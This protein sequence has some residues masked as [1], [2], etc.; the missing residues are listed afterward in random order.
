MY[1]QQL[2][3]AIRAVLCGGA[4]LGGLFAFA[5]AQAQDSNKQEPEKKEK[6]EVAQLDAVE[7]LGS[8]IKRTTLETA[9]P[10]ITINREELDRTG[11][12]NI[13]EILK[14]IAINGP[15]LSL[16]T[17]NGNTSGIQRVNLRGCGAQR[18]LV[19]VNGK[20]W[21]N[22]AGLGG[23]V[24]LSSIPTAAIENVEILK[25]GASSLY[26]TDAICGVINF[27]MKRNWNGAAFNAYYGQYDQD[28]GVTKA[29]DFTFGHA[30]DRW[31]VL[32]NASW[33]DF[34]GVSAGNRDIS[35][36][37]LYGFPANVSTPGRA[38]PTTPYGNFSVG[39]KTYTL[40]PSKVGCLPNQACTAKNDFK[41]YDFL[42]D[43]YNFAPVNFLQLPQTTR[44]LYSEVTYNFADNLRLRVNG[45][46]NKR[47]GDAQLAAQPLSSGTV[48]IN[49]VVI[50]KSYSVSKD[51]VYNPFGAQINSPTFRPILYPRQYSQDQITRRFSANLEGDFEAFGHPINWDAGGSYGKNKFTLTK[52]GFEDYRKFVN[53]VG[54][55][56]IKDGKAYCG[57]PAAPIDGCVP[58]NMFGGPNGVTPDMFN[59]VRA[60]L[61][62]IQS[63]KLENYWANISGPIFA[64]PAGDLAFATGFEYRKESGYDIP[65]PLTASGNAMNDVPYQP[66]SGSFNVKEFYA[67]L[68][69]PLLKEVPF[70]HALDLS[71]ATRH[72]NY[73]SFG[74]TDNPK[75]SLQWRPIEDL[76]V[77][78]S[79][80]KGFR[81]PSIGELYSGVA[82]G[83]PSTNDPCSIDSPSTVNVPS[84]RANCAAAGVPTGFKKQNAQSFLSTGG[85]A[86]L[87]PETSKNKTL[88]FVYAPSFLEGFDTSID[89]YNIQISNAIGARSAQSIIDGCYINGIADRCKLI[90]RDPTGQFFNNPGEII[91]IV[92]LNQNFK[93]GLEIE[94]I[95]FGLHYKFRTDSYGD[96]RFNW[97]NAYII[98]YGD[99]GQPKRG[100]VNGDGDISEGNT[101]GRTQITGSSTG[102]TQF[103]LRSTLNAVW[104]L[105]D[106]SFSGTLE[107]YSKIV[108]TC[109]TATNTA[110]ALKARGVTNFTNYCTDPT[111]LYNKY[112]FDT[113]GKVVAVP[114]VT[115]RTTFNPVVYVDIRASY[116]LPWKGVV[117]A[118]IR[119]LFDKD[120]PISSDAFANSFDPQYR[121]PGRFFY[122]SYNQNFDLF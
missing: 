66:T 110:A 69:I 117:S 114:S 46:L 5:S 61:H 94:G 30:T 34:Q 103:R 115:P 19:L 121:I 119:N 101:I 64:L 106:F 99:I 96:F 51:S 58:F 4:T 35:K 42:T 95:D 63:Y 75:L 36:V 73:S 118:G 22:D 20:R 109:N 120:P 68:A 80:G 33:K 111:F 88:G 16:N 98:Y 71:L 79:W 48:T 24:D 1:K 93:G 112:S 76:L 104:T 49:G 26:G 107:R 72:S 10:V 15:S 86:K 2:P 3:S 97:D 12:A 23:S 28:D 43:G 89:W 32:V 37:P 77:R 82:T 85:N 6:K 31:S 50:P 67:E 100:Q 91:N 44:G 52:T 38:S 41:V 39:G 83:R 11:L 7:V 8:R 21:V 13:G 65:D 108:D 25:D 59:Y 9:Q 122:A 47:T 116:R 40:D 54:P 55:S 29:G 87:Q 14:E 53:A 45:F 56:F 92:G 90:T 113:S 84:I 27:T 81:A 57:T 17:N 18:T 105:K 74:S 62:N 102:S 60:D 78:G 70:A